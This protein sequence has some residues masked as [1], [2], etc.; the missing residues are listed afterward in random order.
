MCPLW[1]MIQVFQTLDI[2]IFPAIVKATRGII[3]AENIDFFE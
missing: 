3:Y 2:R 1:W